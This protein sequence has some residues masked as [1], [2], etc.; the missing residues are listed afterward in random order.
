MASGHEEFRNRTSK[1]KL[2]STSTA[3]SLIHNSEV[4]DHDAPTVS[5][6]S[7]RDAMKLKSNITT[8]SCQ[9]S[10]SPLHAAKLWIDIAHRNR[11]G[12]IGKNDFRYHIRVDHPM[13]A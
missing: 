7:I 12:I 4:G 11:F 10:M 6:L 13:E 8:K 5:H 9:G 3:S 2:I 1:I